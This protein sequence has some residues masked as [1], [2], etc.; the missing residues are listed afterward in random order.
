MPRQRSS[1]DSPQAR[2]PE[3][4]TVP[5]QASSIASQWAFSLE[6]Q[7]SGSGVTSPWHG[8]KPLPSLVQVARPP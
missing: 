4:T 6:A 5:L 1:F 2:P 3:V 7:L 8:P